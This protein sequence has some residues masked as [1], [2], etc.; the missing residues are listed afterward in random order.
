MNCSRVSLVGSGVGEE[1]APGVR[2]GGGGGDAP[3]GEGGGDRKIGCEDEATPLTSPP[4][5]MSLETSEPV[6]T[7]LA[8]E[9]KPA[10]SP[11]GRFCSC[12]CLWLQHKT[13]AQCFQPGGSCSAFPAI[14]AACPMPRAPLG[15][16]PPSREHEQPDAHSRRSLLQILFQNGSPPHTL[17][18][19][20]LETS[21]KVSVC[22][23]V[24][25]ITTEV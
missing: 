6:G 7:A 20:S 8:S 24:L 11:P 13:R 23:R 12:W 21:R 5:A 9:L 3:P 10:V 25:Y 16:V 4:S 1:S 2:G 19:P 18:Y 22:V 17:T 15:S 14:D